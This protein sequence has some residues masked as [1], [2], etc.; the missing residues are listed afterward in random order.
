[1]RTP[2]DWFTAVEN[3]VVKERRV[4]A[5]NRPVYDIMVNVGHN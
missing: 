2:A 4:Y 5:D 3:G 1:M